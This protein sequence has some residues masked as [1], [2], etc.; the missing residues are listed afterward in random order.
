MLG[1]GAGYM[2]SQLGSMRSALSIYYGDLGG[3]YPADLD[4]LNQKYRSAIPELWGGGETA[5]DVPHARGNG[6]AYYDEK[7]AGDTG[8]WGYW[9]SRSTSGM[10]AAIWIDCTHA[11]P[12]GVSWNQY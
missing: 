6:V 1:S 3:Q 2:R 9:I 11:D 7:K 5:Y 8:K 4:S 10:D 12:N